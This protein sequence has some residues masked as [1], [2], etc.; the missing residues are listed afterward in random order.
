[1]AIEA[2]AVGTDR[3]DAFNHRAQMKA[4]A[5][6]MMSAHISADALMKQGVPVKPDAGKMSKLEWLRFPQVSIMDLMDADGPEWSRELLLEIEQDGRYAPYL[7]RQEAEIQDIA[8]NEKITTLTN[9]IMSPMVKP[10]FLLNDIAI[11]SVPSITP[12]PLMARP[13]P[14]PIKKPP[15][16]DTN[17]LSAVKIGKLKINK[18]TANAIM[19]NDVLI[20]KL[21]PICL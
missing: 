9:K 19:P 15:N 16:T 11:I 1:M 14:A 13:I 8:A 17:N 10:V 7:A 4:T 12:P 2:G 6:D 5:L 20:T 18:Q 21:F 3:M